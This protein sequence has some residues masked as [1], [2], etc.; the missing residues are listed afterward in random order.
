MAFIAML[1]FIGKA[2]DISFSYFSRDAIQTIWHVPNVSVEF[3]IG[4]LSNI[5]ITFWC[6]TAAILF[7][8]SKIARDFDKPKAMS[9]F[10]FFSGLLTLFMLID[11][12]F[13]LH[14]VI[15]P[16][17]LNISEKFFYLFYGSSVIALLYLFREFILKTDYILFLLAFGFLASSVITDILA[18]FGINISDIYLFEDGFKFMGIISWFIYFSRACYIGIKPI[19]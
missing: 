14:D 18:A 1:F 16:Y 10:F 8:S 19:K 11:D 15:I 3:Y 7:F 5:G 9:Q 13:L 12:L 4:F 6:F 17:Y 2:N